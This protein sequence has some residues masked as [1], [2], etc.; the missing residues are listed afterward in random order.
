MDAS[1][2]HARDLLRVPG[3]ISLCR[4]PLGIAFPFAVGRPAWAIALMTAAG[5]TDVLGGW[6]ARRFHQQT[7]AGAVLD[8]VMD[9]VFALSAGSTLV[10]GGWLSVG[11]AGGLGARGLR[12]G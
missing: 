8:G 1:G 9:K 2:Y 4:L 6:D 12:G 3:L 5:A 11:P 7:R 10:V